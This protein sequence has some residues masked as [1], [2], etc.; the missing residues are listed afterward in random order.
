VNEEA[1]SPPNTSVSSLGDDYGMPSPASLPST[2]ET[3]RGPEQAGQTDGLELL[4][5]MTG[6]VGYR[7]DVSR[8]SVP[9]YD[10]RSGS[11]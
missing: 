7:R 9:G 5:G 6:S 4:R 11:A 10:N 3:V 2:Y 8:K 1:V